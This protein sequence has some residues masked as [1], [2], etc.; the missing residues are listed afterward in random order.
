MLFYLPFKI[1]NK[2]VSLLFPTMWDVVEKVVTTYVPGLKSR[3]RFHDLK[4][5]A[6]ETDFA[7][8]YLFFT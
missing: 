6:I 2:I 4:G 3:R 8:K 5:S 7:Y 1:D